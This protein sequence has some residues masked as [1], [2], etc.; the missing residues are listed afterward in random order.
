MPDDKV[1]STKPPK[2]WWDKHFPVVRAGL[3][4]AHA[5][6]DDKKLDEMAR[7]TLGNTWHNEMSTKSKKETR[8]AEGKKYG[9][10]PVKKSFMNG[11]TLRKALK[12]QAVQ[13]YEF[14][15]QPVVVA[16]CY[17]NGTFKEREIVTAPDV[18]AAPDRYDVRTFMLMIHALSSDTWNNQP[19]RL[20]LIS[21]LAGELQE[22]AK[23]E[24]KARKELEKKAGGIP[25]K[26]AVGPSNWEL[27]D[28]FFF[29]KSMIWMPVE[30]EEEAD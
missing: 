6:W 24:E 27:K 5:D 9:E 7:A 3:K 14:K 22:R 15:T 23:E 2:D 25:E 1:P 26:G 11:L 13:E 28:K 20:E 18:L 8:E 10:P 19:K 4:K 17:E 16:D 29:G 21:T 30:E 12:Y